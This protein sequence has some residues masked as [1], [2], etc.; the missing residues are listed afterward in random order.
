MDAERRVRAV[1]H[2]DR[3]MRFQCSYNDMDLD[4]I[5]L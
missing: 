4:V 5:G 3:G 2:V 1:A